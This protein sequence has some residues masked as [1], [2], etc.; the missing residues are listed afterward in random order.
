MKKVILILGLLITISFGTTFDE[1]IDAIN[2][3]DFKSALKIFEKLAF[4]NDAKAQYALGIMYSNENNAVRQDYSKAKEWYEKAAIQGHADAQ[5]NHEAFQNIQ[6]NESGSVPS[7]A[8][9]TAVLHSC[10]ADHSLL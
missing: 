2:K 8:C 4:K 7:S 5:Y 3:K 9:H 6:N 10:S 1:G